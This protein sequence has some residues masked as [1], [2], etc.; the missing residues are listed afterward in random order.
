MVDRIADPWGPRTPYGAG[1]EWPVRV[2]TFLDGDLRAEDVD[3]WVQ[4]ASILHSNGDALDIAVRDGRMVG[5]RGRAVDRVNRGRLDPKDL[6]GWQANHS[7][8]RLTRPLV[9]DGDRLVETDWDTAMGRI[10][11]RSKELLDGPG[12]WGHFGFYTTGQLFLEEY[13]TLGV[14]GKA[15]LG[16]PHMDGNT[17]L[18]TAT[19]AAALKATF[20]ADG[21]PGSYTDID[22]C[23]TLALWGHNVAET[24]AVL[25]MRMLDR[26]R[27]PN[28]PAM[29]AVDPR[30]T[31]VTREADLHL[32]IRNGTNM[33]LLNG[34]LRE[35]IRNGWYDE[36][37]V[38]AHT[39]GFD[40]LS[41]TVD[42]YPPERVAEICDVPAA[43]VRRAAE[44]LGGSQRL[45]STVLQGFY[46]SN[47]ATAAACQVNNLHLLRG[48]IGRP[49]AGLYQMNGQPTAQNTR[50]TGADG[51]LPG[52]RNWD[53]PD[54]IAELARL[55][56][57][58]S[59]VIPHWAPPT[60][61]MQIFRYAEQGSIKLLWISATNPA[62]SLP[63]LSR[64]RR[65]L[66]RPELFV[67]V[68]DLFLTETA[69]FA[70][71]VLP[72][73]TWGEKTGTFT[74]V[75]RTVHLSEKAVEPPGEARPD[76]D[77][78]L[79][80]ARRMDFRDR[81]GRPLIGWTSPEEAF[82][83]WKECSRGRP[84]DY[85]GLSYDRLRGGSGIQWPCTDARP[86]G[87]ERLYVDG[88]FPTDPEVCE[89]YGQDLATG[90]E[91]LADEYRAK[92]PGGRAFLHADEYRPS[93]EV[94]DAEHPMLLTT[95]RTVYQ[96]HTRTKT[97]RA[98]QLNAAAPDVWVELNPV[99]AERFGIG[100]GDLVGV[101][102]ARGAVQARARL[103][104][105]RPGVVFLP[106]HYGWFD[107]DPADRTPRAA[108]ELTITAWDP[109]SKQ[110][111]FKVAAVAV[112][113][114]ADGGG[115]PAPAPTV[116]GSAPV[117]SGVPATVGG[118]AAEATSQVGGE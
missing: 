95:G 97:G 73:A 62:V 43:D 82:E 10:V 109:V 60:H 86:E 111:L 22:H 49:G 31:A 99:D 25:W 57:V 7:P 77:I 108:N 64:I 14:I 83:A 30:S 48:M 63:D 113:R 46:Q 101:S 21:Q 20:G 2:D 36:A 26:R 79:E 65:I 76:L 84:C 92:Q 118:P 114:L 28:P 27:G 11:G 47:Q 112:T 103:S 104:G 94:P 75:D 102:S 4:S 41:R 8:D 13:Y 96:F 5:V 66:R 19:S 116:G 24:Q 78:F 71:V 91:L 110:P 98:P 58:D 3:Q 44:L 61:A 93:P 12:G 90:A 29:L 72:G 100:E 16:T 67:V 32:P 89:T 45:L 53:N 105:I 117:G 87:T 59:D 9:R 23:D 56:N 1:Q 107:Q 40:E 39:L 52:L 80:Y 17:R 15:G 33:A 38:A 35:V 34:L 51:D 115:V 85:T 69:E 70:D 68:Q 50:E 55:W 6:Y 88:V 37:Y 106:F 18:C 42:G 81:D 74:N 54:H